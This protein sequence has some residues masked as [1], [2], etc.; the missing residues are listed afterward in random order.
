MSANF[1]GL[2]KTKLFVSR[3]A[4]IYNGRMKYTHSRASSPPPLRKKD[5]RIRV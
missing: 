2:Y 4:V 3:E 1:P 5:P